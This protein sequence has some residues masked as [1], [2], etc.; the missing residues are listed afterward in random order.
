[1][2]PREHITLDCVQ[3][4]VD[5][6]AA[7]NTVKSIDF[8]GGDPFLYKEI[9]LGGCKRAN[10]NGLRS[11]V[12]TSAYW[13]SSLDRAF[14][15]LRPL[16]L[17]G[18]N[19]ICLSY[20]D[21]HAEFVN[22]IAI[23]NA[24]KAATALGIEVIVLVVVEPES[25]IDGKYMADLLGVSTRCE[26]GTRIRERAIN[27][28][29]RASEGVSEDVQKARCMSSAVYRGPCHSVLRHITVNPDGKIMACCGVI[30]FR[31]ELQI[32]DI[33]TDRIDMVGR[34]ARESP[35]LQW[36]AFEGPVEIV[37]Q[38]TQGAP[39][40]IEETEFDGICTACDALFSRQELKNRL[41]E[42]IVEKQASLKLQRAFFEG[43]G[44]FP[45]SDER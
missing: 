7:L 29:G 44:L 27:S 45:P 25:K 11:G 35:L 4:V 12:T 16:S 21:A 3:R 2:S 8:V 42:K 31:H 20:D 10:Q 34:Q 24:H 39:K 6:A 33:A 22:E 17:A 43:L 37:R 1:M 26:K 14:D 36:I 18:L 23:L 19:E 9:L 13:A 30:P 28:V 38:I 32:G 41:K 15:V 5:E 40:P